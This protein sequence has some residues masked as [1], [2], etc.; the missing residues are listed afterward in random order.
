MPQKPSSALP[1]AQSTS[2]RTKR[3]E[4]WKYFISIED[5]KKYKN[6]L[7]KFLNSAPF[8]QSTLTT[9]KNLT[10]KSCTI[11]NID[12]DHIKILLG[13]LKKSLSIFDNSSKAATAYVNIKIAKLMIIVEN[14]IEQ[15]KLNLATEKEKTELAIT[16]RNKIFT[17]NKKEKSTYY[18]HKKIAKIPN[19]ESYCFL[20]MDKLRD[21]S[22]LIDYKNEE[23]KCKSFNI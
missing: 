3:P 13:E 7:N 16:I 8:D 5:Y 14:K 20:G 17:S 19:V 22:S 15:D 10:E 2:S 12:I 6:I 4:P 1:R 11:Q 23:G 9:V 18:A 21:I